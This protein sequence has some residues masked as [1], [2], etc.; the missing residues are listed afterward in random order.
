VL[1]SQSQP[2]ALADGR[3]AGGPTGGPE[4]TGLA[5]RVY[6]QVKGRILLGQARPGDVMAAHALADELSVSRTPVHEALKR[7]VGEGYLAALPRVGYAVTPIDVDAMRDLFE[8]RIRL[9]ALSAELAAKVWA[10][11][12]TASFLAADQVVQRR[13]QELRAAGTPVELTQFLHAE[14]KRFHLMIA[15]IGGNKRLQQLISDLQDETQRFWSL[16]PA[17]Q[18]ISRVFLA[19]AAHQAILDALATGDPATAR[20][21]VVSH[22]RDG[23]RMMVQAVV[24]AVP[25][26]DDLGA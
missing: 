19:D 17:D 10:P 23:V 16:L 20:A 21:A 7:L 11:E 12:H 8:V 13:H 4:P 26:A 2:T 6:A 15:D 22:L 1:S 9:E 24:P 5:D 25:P 14:H 18:L 3:P